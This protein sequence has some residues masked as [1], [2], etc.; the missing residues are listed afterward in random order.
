MSSSYEYPISI[1]DEHPTT[2]VIQLLSLCIRD[3]SLGQALLHFHLFGDDVVSSSACLCVCGCIV[4]GGI[5]WGTK[6]TIRENRIVPFSQG[7]DE[8]GIPETGFITH[9]A[10][11]QICYIWTESYYTR[12]T[13]TYVRV[14][15][16]HSLSHPL[17]CLAFV[18]VIN[19][20]YLLRGRWLGRTI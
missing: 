18:F 11:S 17:L 2:M 15:K 8:H 20:S 6:H 14:P 19:G 9:N 16:S 10:H 3:K 7:R 1:D 13:C 12:I 5:R 4:N